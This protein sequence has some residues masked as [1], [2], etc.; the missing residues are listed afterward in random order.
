M[1]L[2]SLKE[3]RG[4]IK[5]GNL[6]RFF[7][8]RRFRIWTKFSPR[9]KHQRNVF[10]L[11]KSLRKNQWKSNQGQKQCADHCS[12]EYYDV[13]LR[14]TDILHQFCMPWDRKNYKRVKIHQKFQKK[15]GFQVICGIAVKK[16]KKF[17]SKIQ[18]NRSMIDC[19]SWPLCANVAFLL[20]I[21]WVA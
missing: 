20:Q 21:Y 5:K 3:S 7:L 13:I 18:A 2:F 1:K 19:F 14:L 12:L 11:V 15:V 6:I 17:Y 8:G 9:L 10:M 16:D 4:L